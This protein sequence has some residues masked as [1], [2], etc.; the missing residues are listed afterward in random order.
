[1]KKIIFILLMIAPSLCWGAACGTGPF[2]VSAVGSDA[3]AGTSI[4]TAWAHHPWDT[5]ATGVAA[6]TLAQ[7]NTVYMRR[8]DVWW[9]TYL[10][11]SQSG[12]VGHPITTT[13]I[14]TFYKTSAADALPILSSGY[15]TT[16][17]TWTLV[18]GGNYQLTTP[19]NI[20][21]LP[22]AIWY[23]STLLT[24]GGGATPSSGAW[25][26]TGAGPY[27]IY[28]NV[29]GSSAPPTDGT[30]HVAMQNYTILTAG[31]YQIFDSLDLRDCNTTVGG[32]FFQNK[33]I[34][35]ML[36]NSKIGW[37]A[38]HASY[39]DLSTTANASCYIVGNTFAGGAKIGSGISSIRLYGGAAGSIID[40]SG[41]IISLPLSEGI[42]TS[43]AGPVTA[44][45]RNNIVSGTQ[46]LGSTSHGIAIN[47]GTGWKIYGNT[48]YNIG[49]SNNTDI[50]GLKIDA[51]SN[52][53]YNNIIHSVRNVGMYING[54]LNDVSNNVMYN[55]GYMTGSYPYTYPTSII[56]Y[57]AGHGG[58]AI[59]IQ[60][61]SAGNLIRSNY[62]YNSIVGIGIHTTGGSGGNIIAYNFGGPFIVNG[63]GDYADGNPTN[64]NLFYNNSVYHS[65][66]PDNSP[67]Y[68][69][70]AYHTQDVSS[71][72]G[73]AAFANNICYNAVASTASQCMFVSRVA[74]TVS[75]YL[76]NNNW[77]GVAGAYLGYLQGGTPR[78][79][80]SSWM[81][82]ARASALFGDLAGVQANTESGSISEN[83]YFI[84]A[85]TGNFIPKSPHGY[86]NLSASIGSGY[87]VMG[88]TGRFDGLGYTCLLPDM[89]AICH[90]EGGFGVNY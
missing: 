17:W 63:F 90:Q 71:G 2:Y 78:T 26:Y 5:N 47:V 37:S 88:V 51:S 72:S 41:N 27:V 54:N 56:K 79:T 83:P 65:P 11:S 21:V 60:L 50:I 74:G 62:I 33:R 85:T 23:G 3:S 1:M 18:S 77:S 89:G 66:S 73:K 22:N 67:A 12:A 43:S 75:V 64:R 24:S 52:Y 8:G 57:G 48:I 44:T 38:Y 35:N 61:T 6:C 31:D 58:L 19:A 16:A 14:N 34:S 70:H 28:V 15:N 4:A 76:Q 55:I 32:C 81:T 13:S 30:L 45:I 9:Q 69:G 36:S 68:T 87:N 82:D 42:S 40:V 49:E 53:V 46:V 20:T 25:G 10:T 59:D 29:N 84:D 39:I 80:L 7:D 86:A